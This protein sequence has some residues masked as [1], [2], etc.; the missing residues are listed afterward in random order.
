MAK[1]VKLTE[2]QIKMLK[3]NYES[4]PHKVI[5]ITEGQFGRLFPSKKK[6]NE[7]LNSFPTVV[8]FSEEVV[9]FLKE[10]TAHQSEA[11]LDGYWSRIG[12]NRMQL[13]KWLLEFDIIAVVPMEGDDE[14][15]VK[16]KGL[17]NKLKELYTDF[18]FRYDTKEAEIDWEKEKE[19]VAEGMIGLGDDIEIEETTTAGGVGG[20]YEAPM[21]HQG[22][23]KRDLAPHK[24]LNEEE[25]D[26]TT[27]SGAA[28]GSYEQPQMWAKDKKNWRNGNQTMYP[29]GKIVDKKKGLK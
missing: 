29:N 20:S 21:G 25:L 17:I 11:R 26:E 24:E 14:Y 1:K 16:K 15:K 23:I 3:E 9:H 18:E 22:P 5:R 12:A 19:E 8:E 6:L 10:L 27:M 7:N 13:I 28:T 2:K 4:K